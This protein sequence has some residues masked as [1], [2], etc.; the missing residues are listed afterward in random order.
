MRLHGQIS[1]FPCCGNHNLLLHE[2]PANLNPT[3][4]LELLLV[5]RHAAGHGPG[6][7]QQLPRPGGTAGGCA[8]LLECTL[9]E[10]QISGSLS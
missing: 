7:P 2:I 5:P 4:S 3:S 10:F 1:A 6:R 9:A 8:G